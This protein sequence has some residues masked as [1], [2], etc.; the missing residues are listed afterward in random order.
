MSRILVIDDD[1][2]VCETMQSLITR[3]KLTCVSVQTIGEGLKRLNE[4]PFDVVFLDVQLPDGNGL[5]ALPKIKNT[6]SDPE[7]IILTG[8]GDPDGAELAIQGGVWDYLV[9]PSP[10]KIP[11]LP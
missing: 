5:D 8:R 4:E 2:Q 7:V 1:V 3:M 9:K 10:S 6:P 11:C